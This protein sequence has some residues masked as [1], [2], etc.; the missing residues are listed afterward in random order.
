M[1]KTLPDSPSFRLRP[2][3]VAADSGGTSSVLRVARAA[4]VAR[5]ALLPQRSRSARQ[6]AF[7]FIRGSR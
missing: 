4:A 3:A 7:D 2:A 6:L 5:A 1:P